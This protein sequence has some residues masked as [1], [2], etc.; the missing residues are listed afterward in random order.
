MQGCSI[1][2]YPKS[3]A[4][5]NADAAA[6][7]KAGKAFIVGEF[8]WNDANGGDSLSNFLMV[9]LAKGYLHK[10]VS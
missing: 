1:H 4:N 9:K 3:I 7:T 2:Y 5:M 10:V 8:D 6:A